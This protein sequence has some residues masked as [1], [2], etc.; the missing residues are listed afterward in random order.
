M[1]EELENPHLP[2][3]YEYMALG[4][5]GSNPHAFHVQKYF[6][7]KRYE[8]EHKFQYIKNC[9]IQDRFIPEQRHIFVKCM[10]ENKLLSEDDFNKMEDCFEMLK[11]EISH[12]E[13]IVFVTSNVDKNVQRIQKRNRKCE[14]GQIDIEYLKQ[15]HSKYVEFLRFLKQEG[16]YGAKLVEIN[17]NDLNSEEVFKIA[18]EKIE[19]ILNESQ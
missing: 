3:F 13:I 10:Y 4:L 6:L 15:L 1:K 12:P 2:K 11:N 17:T 8:K 7:E 14:V 19:E 5:K 9:L 18:Q 16:S